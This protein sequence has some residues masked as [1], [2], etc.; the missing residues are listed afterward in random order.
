MTDNLSAGG[1]FEPSQAE[2]S[3]S[4]LLTESSR[5][6][7]RRHSRTGHHV[8]SRVA[9]HASQLGSRDY[10]S[11]MKANAKQKAAIVGDSVRQR[12]NEERTEPVRLGASSVSSISA[13]S[14]HSSPSTSVS[15][16]PVFSTL[17]YQPRQKASRARLSDNS[18][19]FSTS[20]SLPSAATTSSR[21]QQQQQHQLQDEVYPVLL[22]GY[23]FKRSH[24][25]SP[26]SGDEELYISLRGFVAR[27]PISQGRGQRMFNL[28]ARQLARLP[29]PLSS[30][31]TSVLLNTQ[32]SST[33]DSH[34]FPSVPGTDQGADEGHQPLTERIAQEVTDH[35]DEEVLGKIVEKVGALPIDGSDKHDPLLHHHDRQ[36]DNDEDDDLQRQ[37][38]TPIDSSSSSVVSSLEPSVTS[39]G[40][41]SRASSIHVKDLSASS[42]VPT[43]NID[44]GTTSSTG[45]VPASR[46]SRLKAKGMQISRSTS[47]LLP[48]QSGSSTTS[49]A[50]NAQLVGGSQY[51]INRS[52]EEIHELTSNLN[53]RLADF[54][55]F[56]VAAR[57]VR[58]EVQASFEKSEAAAEDGDDDKSKREWATLLAQEMTT[59]TNGMYQ[60]RV[61]LGSLGSLQN[62]LRSLRARAILIADDKKTEQETGWIPLTLP[63]VSE[64][65]SI[66]LI[67]DIDDTIRKTNVLQGLT[68]V[69]RQVFV[70][71][72]EEVVVPGMAKWYSAL[73]NLS[74]PVGI[75]FVS[76]AP[77]ELW[78]PI[79]QFLQSAGMPHGHLHLKSYSSEVEGSLSNTGA[80]TTS[81]SAKSKTSL[82][83]TWLQPASARKKAAIVSILTDFPNSKFLLVGDTGELDL[84]LYSELSTKY[85][86]Q[87]K[88][89]Y[90][91][92]VSSDRNPLDELNEIQSAAASRSSTTDALNGSNSR[93]SSP[94]LSAV[95]SSPIATKLKAP[96]KNT[97]K[98]DS[99]SLAGLTLDGN[100]PPLNLPLSKR[101]LPSRASTLDTNTAKEGN[102][103][104]MKRPTFLHRHTSTATTSTPALSGKTT[105]SMSQNPSQVK[106]SSSPDPSI[107]ESLKEASQEQLFQPTDIQLQQPQ[108]T[109]KQKVPASS[110]SSPSA[111]LARV[112]KA[113]NMIPEHVELHFFKEGSEVQHLSERLVHTLRQG[114]TQ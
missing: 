1:W 28:M 66:R 76:N 37:S 82:L 18:K 51:W 61:N 108:P 106:L 49:Q 50:A 31:S 2:A 10:W 52:F 56:R 7:S 94:L 93:T 11:S 107:S 90:L 24:R 96:F 20:A 39:D 35:V 68:S 23:T 44:G 12:I 34:F 36:S 41:P 13:A 26:I 92:N 112:L 64:R 98:N 111:F 84:E 78:K 110:A 73:S 105:Q 67:S 97:T 89:L 88:A 74:H 99:P 81:S 104:A 57:Q 19:P 71:G 113:K 59:D 63:C 77:I 22:P 42:A 25:D 95:S 55:I 79:R 53:Q 65:T 30:S 14:F 69:F 3:S 46:L 101:A 58:I 47:T 75:H 29:K 43:D 80:G 102:V 70:L 87:I 62:S 38:S 8:R 40:D 85:P 32:S 9:N 17:A 27:R 114:T 5:S 16:S 86:N 54:W 109:A 21:K 4:N 60:L 6:Y 15:T 100:I 45:T 91:R 83:S 33:D 72:H 48:P 103:V